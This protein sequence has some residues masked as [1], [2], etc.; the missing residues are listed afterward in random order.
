MAIVVTYDAKQVK[1]MLFRLPLELQDKAMAM[2]INKT[3]AKARVEMARQVSNYFNVKYNEAGGG[4]LITKVSAKSNVI[5]ASLYPTSLS[6]K[7]DYKGRAMNVIHFLEKKTSGADAKRRRKAGTLDELFFKFKKR[8]GSVNIKAD[9]DK[10]K[11]FIGNQGRT[12]F[13]RNGEKAVKSDKEAIEPVQVIDLKQMFNMK[14]INESVLK[15]AQ[16]DLLIE[17][18]RAVDQVL[19]SM[20]T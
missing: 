10:S 4:L 15:K 13:R 2:A 12:V 14:T 17:T 9:G 11:P 1:A 5:S 19:R 7:I 3:A 18:Q 16:D 6:G 20:P 8:G